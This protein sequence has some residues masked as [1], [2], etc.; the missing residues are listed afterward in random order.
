MLNRR[1]TKDIFTALKKFLGIEKDLSKFYEFA[2]K[3]QVL[4]SL[5]KRFLGLKPP[6]FQQF[7]KALSMV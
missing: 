7:S 6:R 1:C 3:D 2:Q 4:D 5:V